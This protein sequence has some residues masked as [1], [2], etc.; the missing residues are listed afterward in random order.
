MLKRK[1]FLY[2]T[3]FF[4]GISVMAIELG[5]SRLLAPY[6]SSSQIVWTIIIGTIMIAMAL[7]N[8]I[9]G[10]IADRDPNPD[11]LYGRLLIVAVWCAAIP[12]AGK[13]VIGA[14]SVALAALGG[15]NFLIW[16]SLLSCLLLF[17][18]PLML[19]GTVSPSLVKYTVSSLNESGRTV[20]ELNALNTIGSIIGT[21]LPTFV[22][23]PAVGTSWT[24]IIFAS[25]L[26]IISLIYFISERRRLIRCA[27]ALVLAVAFSVLASLG[28]FAFGAERGATLDE[29]E[30]IY[31]YLQVIET[32]D[33]VRL[34]TNVMFGV[35]SIM[36][37]NASL[38]GMYY[39]Y[40]L[41]APIMAGAKD[42]DPLNVLILG[43]G[44]GTYASECREYF[45]ASK[46]EG[47]EI[48]RKIIDLAY[49][50]FGVDP[51]DENIKVTEFD[52]RAY[53]RGAGK[54]DVIMVDTYRDITIPF[55]LSS[56]E[57]FRE[58]KD[59]LTDDGVMVVNLNMISENAGSIN[60][61]ICDTIGAVFESVAYAD[62]GTNREVFASADTGMTERFRKDLYSEKGELTALML[63]VR[64]KL[65]EY[66]P[67]DLIL[68][69]DKAPVELLGMKVID[70]MIS[71]ELEYYREQFR[72]R[73]LS[74]IIDMLS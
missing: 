24:F 13:Y 73:S 49:S 59:H 26:L 7:G 50:R 62:V 29:D 46:I 20:G 56:L 27:V 66:E 55:Q 68:T 22:T 19:L 43:F 1:W 10:R 58:V 67:G 18:F 42:K 33:E 17:V 74:E 63:T 47:V 41:A 23:I 53:L 6:F 34:S 48:D 39:D 25:V 5:A 28:S 69:D 38:T 12:F 54:Y 44:S 65:T 30:S 14:V 3:E 60:D 21:F 51:D 4:A 64:E 37:K 16:A 31:N 11:R 61:W 9:G 72:G 71:D 32:E 8:I 36:K 40:A 45:P 70:E 52:G 15:G 57:F 2:V 35:Q